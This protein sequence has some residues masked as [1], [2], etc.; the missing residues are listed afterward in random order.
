MLQQLDWRQ[1]AAVCM[2]ALASLAELLL[3][4]PR[5]MASEVRGVRGRANRGNP[6][7]L[8]MI[9]GLAGADGHLPR[10]A[11]HYQFVDSNDL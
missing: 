9:E 6:L 1:Q 11:G 4:Q 5:T 10:G 7:S 3:E 8:A 2:R